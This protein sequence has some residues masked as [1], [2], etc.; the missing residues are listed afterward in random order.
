M[1]PNLYIVVSCFKTSHGHFT[2]GFLTCDE[3]GQTELIHR[4]PH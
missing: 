2:E 4:W 3:Q 1:K